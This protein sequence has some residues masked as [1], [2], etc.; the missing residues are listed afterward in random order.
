MICD[1]CGRLMRPQTEAPDGVTVR[2]GGDGLCSTCFSA[3]SAGRIQFTRI[4]GEADEQAR[5]L[6]LA[7]RRR[8]TEAAAADARAAAVKALVETDD[9]GDGWQKRGS[10]AQPD[11]PH[12]DL[13]FSDK[14]HDQVRAKTIC[15]ACPV[16]LRC[17]VAGKPERWGIW[18]GAD[19]TTRGAH[20]P[21]RRAEVA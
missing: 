19:H 18:A 17:N 16:R 13:W 3:R 14:H 8:A 9:E 21:D 12:P 20:R 6:A 11:A 1:A 15:A 7:E 10:C 2:Y 4:P 5:A